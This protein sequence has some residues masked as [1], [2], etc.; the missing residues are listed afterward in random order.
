MCNIT[1]YSE[2]IQIFM[3]KIAEISDR[4]SEIIEYLDV[5]PNSFAKKLDYKRSQTVYDILNGKIKPSYDFFR[6]FVN[7]EYSEIFNIEW[8]LAGKGNKLKIDKDEMAAI[9]VNEKAAFYGEC[10]LCPEKD[11]MINFLNNEIELLRAEKEEIK[12]DCKEQLTWLR[13]QFEKTGQ[14]PPEHKRRYG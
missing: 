7:S 13:Q 1:E 4:L 12:E 3:N 11:K 10:K 14:N 9:T 5:N 6:R 2:L 8:L